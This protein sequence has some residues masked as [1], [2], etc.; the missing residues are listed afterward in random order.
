M[1]TLI[2]TSFFFSRQ[3]AKITNAPP[4]M[5]ALPTICYHV[6]RGGGRKKNSWTGTPELQG[7]FQHYFFVFPEAKFR[8]GEFSSKLTLRMKCARAKGSFIWPAEAARLAVDFSRRLLA[9]TAIVPSSWKRAIQMIVC[10]AIWNLPSRRKGARHTHCISRGEEIFDMAKNRS[11]VSN[12]WACI[13]ALDHMVELHIQDLRRRSP[14]SI[15]IVTSA[16]GSPESRSFYERCQQVTECP[17]DKPIRLRE[18]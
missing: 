9:Q 16:T 14:M 2:W 13:R 6:P 17:G 11:T 10:F 12:E 18:N 1:L 15:G 5:A 3:L 4:P 7:G 8:G